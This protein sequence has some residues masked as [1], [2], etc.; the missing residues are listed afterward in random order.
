[1]L[2]KEE[3]VYVTEFFPFCWKLNPDMKFVINKLKFSISLRFFAEL[4]LLIG[5]DHVNFDMTAFSNTLDIQIL[6]W[7]Q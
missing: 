4:C 7:Q 1:M 5:I 3:F 2:S 6:T